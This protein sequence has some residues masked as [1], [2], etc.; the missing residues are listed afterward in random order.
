[1]KSVILLI[2][3][4]LFSIG[5]QGQSTTRV[6]KGLVTDQAGESLANKIVEARFYDCNDDTNQ[7][8][9]V[10]SSSNAEGY[11]ELSL[12]VCDNEEIVVIAYCGDVF[13]SVDVLAF[14]SDSKVVN[15]NFDCNY[16]YNCDASFS[17]TYGEPD[18]KMDAIPFYFKAINPNEQNYFYEWFFLGALE[19]N[20][21]SIDT[22]MVY[23]P[24]FGQYTV[25]MQ[26]YVKGDPFNIV[27]EFCQTINADL[28][29]QSYSTSNTE[30]LSLEENI[31]LFPNPSSDEIQLNFDLLKNEN[32]R[33]EISNHLG[34]VLQLQD[35]SFSKGKNQLI[36]D[37]SD[38]A[39]GMYVVSV[40][41]SKANFSRKVMKH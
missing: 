20:A 30:L 3:T 6:I 5:L 7:Q 12:D 33:I 1:M 21:L 34:Q 24:T 25:C 41:S 35:L 27:C 31:K 8:I 28:A 39:S 2:Y 19:E 15:F 26:S 29:F 11:Y 38:F 36:L 17:F 22:P 13:Q 32:L 14:A 9:L 23:Y 4:V 18:L 16:D 10:Q 37:L 40:K